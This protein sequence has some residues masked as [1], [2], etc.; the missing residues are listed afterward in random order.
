[1]NTCGACLRI[2]VSMAIRL[3]AES[4]LFPP[5][6][7][8]RLCVKGLLISFF[9]EDF[10]EPLL[11]ELSQYIKYIYRQFSSPVGSFTWRY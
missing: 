4:F 2:F 9:Q 6:M 1:M 8:L 7:T 10:L 11:S 5:V 3:C